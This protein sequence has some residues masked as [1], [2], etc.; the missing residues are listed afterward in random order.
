MEKKVITIFICTLLAITY[1]SGC[2]EKN[3][4]NGKPNN[5]EKPMIIHIDDD[6]D[7]YTT[8]WGIDHFNKI[9]DG[10]NN[11]NE[12]GTIYIYNGIYSENID[13]NKTI[14]LIGEDK[15]HTII[16]KL[17]NN[18]TLKITSNNCTI[19]NISITNNTYNIGIKIISNNNTLINNIIDGNLNGVSI[20]TKSDNVI[21]D[22][23]ISNSNDGINLKNTRNTTI[24]NNDIIK[25]SL[26]GI[27][28]DNSL[29]V[30]ITDNNFKNNGIKITGFLSDCDSH[31]IEN[32]TVNEKPILYYKNK[33]EITI[34]NDFAQ[35][36][37]VNCSNLSIKNINFPNMTIPIQ[38]L[39]CSN[40]S[41]ENNHFESIKQNALISY[42]SDYTTIT[43]NTIKGGKGIYISNSKNNK[44]S[45]NN[46]ENTSTAIELQ[47]SNYNN[48]SKNTLFFN[49]EYGL[50][51]QSSS[52]YNIISGNKIYNNQN[53]MRLKSARQNEVYKNEFNKN[54]KTGIYICCG[55][56]DNVIYNNSFIMNL[57]NAKYTTSEENYFYKDRYGN[58]WDD[59][60][61]KYPNATQINGIWN[62]PYKIYDTDFEDQ[63][64]L[65]KPVTT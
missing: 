32:N 23:I 9:Q 10:I 52:N 29:N 20:E 49:T 61:E 44:I 6:Y 30:T 43:G 12:S 37:F 14:K 38:I 60:Q 4:Q 55:T 1:Y 50:F 21:S 7:N 13:I 56:E 63:Y 35:L 39:Y 24:N 26:N 45:Q 18:E 3:P 22:N 36:I 62:I 65:V 31:I 11:I 58:Y 15:F 64:P 5:I 46:I 47:Y 2:L 19:Q 51:I 16:N 8:G 34:P 40:I 17:N 59:Y 54:T 57:E 25:N 42:Y 28:L 27:N 48:I 53:G 33:K 41:I